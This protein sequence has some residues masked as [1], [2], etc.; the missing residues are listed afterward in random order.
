MAVNMRTL[1]R[2]TNVTSN[3][4]DKAPQNPYS[5]KSPYCMPTVHTVIATNNSGASN[6]GEVGVNV[7]WLCRSKAGP[8]G[9]DK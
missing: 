3:Y 1:S 6:V 8:P 9:L 7:A 2:K 4:K 5:A